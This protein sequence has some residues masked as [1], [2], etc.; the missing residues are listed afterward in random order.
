MHPLHLL[1][2]LIFLDGSVPTDQLFIDDMSSSLS[3]FVISFNSL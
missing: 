3:F 2:N 1:E